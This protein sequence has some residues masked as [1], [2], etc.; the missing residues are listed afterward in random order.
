MNEVPSLF[1]G[2]GH[3][4]AAALEFLGYVGVLKK[5]FLLEAGRF[6]DGTCN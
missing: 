6:L 4:R 2:R 5:D 1:G 3:I